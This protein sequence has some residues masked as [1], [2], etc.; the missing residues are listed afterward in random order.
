MSRPEL[1]ETLR[2]LSGYG[3]EAGF[4]KRA[5]GKKITAVEVKDDAL[6][7]VMDDGLAFKL[8]DLGQDCCEHRYMTCDGDDLSYYAG[9]DLL[10][11]EIREAP[12]VEDMYEIHE[13]EFLVVQTSKGEF[14]VSSHNEHNGY[15]G[16]F[17][18]QAVEL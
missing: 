5:I 9:A 16:G 3:N 17:S 15:Y 13:V 10:G 12:A 2:R 18:V 11:F 1:D 6:R 8:A 7:F 4:L 14:V